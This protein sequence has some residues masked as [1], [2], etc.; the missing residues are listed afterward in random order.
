MKSLKITWITLNIL[1]FLT[2]FLEN[3][4]IFFQTFWTLFFTLCKDHNKFT[5]TKNE[6]IHEKQTPQGKNKNKQLQETLGTV[7]M[8]A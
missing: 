3:I 7:G 8:I 6:T 5:K 4:I 2:L 1:F